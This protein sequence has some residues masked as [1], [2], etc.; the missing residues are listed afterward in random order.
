M[1]GIFKRT[2][3]AFEPDDENAK[4]IFKKYKLGDVIEL[5]HKARRNVKFHRKYFAMLNLTFQN[6]EL[7]QNENDFREA[8]QIA[9][10]YFHYQKQL[11]GSEVKR[12][13]SI[14]F[15]KMDDVTFADLY[16][17]VFDVCLKILGCKSEELEMELL[18]FD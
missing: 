5:E 13:D 6:Q 16:S 18:R 4:N 10:G 7:T 1:K 9:A 15:E 11:D 14:S 3:S 8:V 2:W 12:S 17:K